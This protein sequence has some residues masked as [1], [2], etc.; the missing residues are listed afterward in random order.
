MLTVA[1]LGAAL[2]APLGPGGV[3]AR[4][5]RA[6]GGVAGL[7]AVVWACAT[8][9]LLA[10][11]RDASLDFAGSPARRYLPRLLLYCG[12]A[13]ADASVQQ[14]V[15]WLLALLAG[16]DMAGVARLTG[17]YKG[18]QSFGAALS[19]ALT[20]AVLSQ[21]AQVV[22]N[23]ALLLLSVPPAALAASE[24]AA[25]AD[26]ATSA[27]DGGAGENGEPRVAGGTGTGGDMGGGG[28]VDEGSALLKKM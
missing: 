11:P 9:L 17:V 16:G 21:R 7:S 3:R 15:Y 1:L 5:L 28:G 25:A 19:W 12:F 10:G 27:V 18:V 8:A 2:D 22:V 4:A 14:W 20:A 26:V 13:A 23:V 6:L 24:L